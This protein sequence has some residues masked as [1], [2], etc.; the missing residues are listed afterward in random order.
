MP[1]NEKNTIQ[2]FRDNKFLLVKNFISPEVIEIA[3]EY[4]QMKVRAGHVWMQETQVPG[5]PS[6]YA[7]TLTET[8]MKLS[9]PRVEK[10]IGKELYP[11]FSSMRVYKKGDVLPPHID[12]PAGEFGMTLCLGF[13]ISN[14]EDQDY[15]WKIYMDTS[16]DF[17]HHPTIANS[18]LEMENGI[19]IEMEPGDCIL[20][21]GCENRHWR[22][23]F[24]GNS[25]AQAFLMFVDK[26]GPYSKFR[27]DTRPELGFS[28][29]TIS[30]K[31]PHSYFPEPEE[32]SYF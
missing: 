16:K 18:E 17:R 24:K 29:D 14:M 1:T 25:H 23:A 28:A 2:E 31:G 20:Y 30:D 11:T 32:V 26:N 15:R 27:Y 4:M 13:D 10:L 19:G 9:V 5:T 12:R 21:Y 8:L 6:I 3:Y 7:D 22:N